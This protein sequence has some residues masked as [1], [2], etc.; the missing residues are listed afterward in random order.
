MILVLPV[1]NTSAED[2]V[3]GIAMA[4]DLNEQH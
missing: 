3:P 2:L 4:S 1:W